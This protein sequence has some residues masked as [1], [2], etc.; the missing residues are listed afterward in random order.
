M[1]GELSKKFDELKRWESQQ[2]EDRDKPKAANFSS[3]TDS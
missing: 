3:A 1:T 2:P